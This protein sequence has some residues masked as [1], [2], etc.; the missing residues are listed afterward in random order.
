MSTFSIVGMGCRYPGADNLR[1]YWSM[2]KDKKSGISTN[3]HSSKHT[4]S[5]SGGRID[6]HGFDPLRFGISPKEAATMDPQQ[7]I[8]LH[9]VD[10]AIQD[11]GMNIHGTRTGVFIGAGMYDHGVTTLQR[12]E[13]TNTHTMTSCALSIIANRISYTFGLTGPSMVIDTACS[14]SM[15][16]LHV[17][18]R[19]LEAGDCDCIIVGGV[20]IISI[21]GGTAGFTKLGVVSD[22]GQCMAFDQQADGYIRSEGMGAIVIKRQ[23]VA[24]E[25]RDRIYASINM[26]VLNH[27]GHNES[28]TMPNVDQ[29]TDLLRKVYNFGDGNMTVPVY[30]EAHGTGTSV[31]DPIECRAISSTF[32]GNVISIGS[33]KNNIGHTECAAAMASIIKCALMVYHRG[34]LPTINVS[35]PN[36]AIDWTSLRLVQEYTPYTSHEDMVIGINCFGFGGANGHVRMM[37]PP[38]LSEETADRDDPRWTPWVLGASTTASLGTLHTAWQ[39]YG[40]DPNTT[41]TINSRSKGSRYIMTALTPP[42]TTTPSFG[43]VL[44]PIH[45]KPLVFV[46]NGQG[47]Q[48]P[49]MGRELYAKF[50]IFRY[51]VDRIDAIWQE[52]GGRSLLET[53]GIFRGEE[54]SCTMEQKTELYSVVYGMVAN[55]THQLAL[56]SLLESIGIKPDIVIGHSIGEFAA[57]YIAGSM[58]IHTTV[59]LLHNRMLALQSVQDCGTMLAVNGVHD[60]QELCNG[61]DEVWMAADNAPGCV[62]LGGTYDAIDAIATR[63]VDQGLFHRRLK[64]T[65]AYHTPLLEPSRNLLEQSLTTLV[66]RKPSIPWISTVTGDQVHVGP[67]TDYFGRN[68]VGAVLFRDA[69]EKTPTD[70]VYV[71]CGPHPVLDGYIA[72]IRPD[73]DRI[74][75]GSRKCGDEETFVKS[76]LGFVT[77]GVDTIRWETVVPKVVIDDAPTFPP[78]NI[79]IRPSTCP[80]EHQYIE[81][82]PRHPLLHRL[83]FNSGDH[84]AYETLLSLN[85]IPFVLDHKIQETPVVPGTMM[86][87]MC[88][89]AAR[90]FLVG[91]TS[92]V[93]V[94]ETTNIQLHR[95]LPASEELVSVTTEIHRVS[96]ESAHVRICVGTTC[97]AETTVSVGNMVSKYLDILPPSLNVSTLQTK[98]HD[99]IYSEL[100][101]V[102][103]SYGETFRL[104]RSVGFDGYTGTGTIDATSLGSFDDYIVHPCILDDALHAV[105][106]QDMNFARTPLPVKIDRVRYYLNGPV[107]TQTTCYSQMT[108]YMDGKETVKVW[109]CD[110]STGTVLSVMD[111][112]Q[113]KPLDKIYRTPRYMYRKWSPDTYDDISNYLVL[114][115]DQ[116]LEWQRECREN[117]SEYHSLNVMLAQSV[118]VA[119]EKYPQPPEDA[120]LYVVRQHARCLEEYRKWLSRPQYELK[121]MIPDATSLSFLGEHM[122][123]H[124]TDPKSFLPRMFSEGGMDDIYRDS[125]TFKT[126]CKYIR[127]ILQSLFRHKPDA[128]I[129]EI[130]AGTGGFTK[131]VIDLLPPSCNYTYS[132]TSTY[133][134]QNGTDMGL[135]TRVVDISQP[136]DGE[137][138]DLIIG[139]DVVH[140]TPD[141]KDTLKNLY[142]S[143]VPSGILLIIDLVPV[144]IWCL[145]VLFHT[146]EGWTAVSDGRPHCCIEKPTWRE[147]LTSVGFHGATTLDAYGVDHDDQSHL[148]VIVAGQKGPEVESDKTYNSEPVSTAMECG[149]MLKTLTDEVQQVRIHAHP[150]DEM[151]AH[152]IEGL[153]RSVAHEHP[154][155]DIRTLIG[156]SSGDTPVV[157]SKRSTVGWVKGVSW[158]EELVPEDMQQ[159]SESPQEWVCVVDDQTHRVRTELTT[160]T[161]LDEHEIRVR[162]RL[163]GLNFRDAAFVIGLINA[164]KEEGN[165]L[166]GEFG[167]TV[168]ETGSGVTEIQ[169]GDT[170]YGIVSS[171][172]SFSSS[173]VAHKDLTWVSNGNLEE[174]VAT[175]IS[176]ITAYIGLIH[177][178]HVGQNEHVVV[179]SGTGALGQACI[180]IALNA[181]CVVFAT[182]STETKRKWLL[183]TFPS[184]S[185]VYPSR[186]AEWSQ[187]IHPSSVDVMIGALSGEAMDIGISA[188]RED[189][190]YIDVGKRDIRENRL[191]G[192][193]M[194]AKNISY[195]SVQVDVMTRSVMGRNLIRN[196]VTTMSTVKSIPIQDIFT[197]SNVN[198]AVSQMLQATHTGKFLISIGDVFPDN[199]ERTS[200][201]IRLTP[202]T[203]VYIA[204]GMCEMGL[205]VALRLAQRGATHIVLTSRRG[206]TTGKQYAIIE[207]IERTGCR[208]V[209]MQSNVIKDK[210]YV[211]DGFPVVDIVLHMA[212]VLRDATLQNTNEKDA[213]TVWDTKVT[214]CKRLYSAFGP[215]ASRFV[216]FSSIA[217]IIGNAGQSYYAAASGWFEGFARTHKNVSSIHINAIDDVGT[218]ACNMSLRDAFYA[219]GFTIQTSSV[220]LCDALEFVLQYTPDQ[221]IMVDEYT[222]MLNI[223]TSTGATVISGDTTALS[224]SDIVQSIVCDVLHLPTD[225]YDTSTPWIS[226]GVD[227]LS[228]VTVVNKLNRQFDTELTQVRV[229]SG[230]CSDD[231][232]SMVIQ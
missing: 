125:A 205:V 186:N 153:V 147:A 93:G 51:T 18:L 113:F 136:I 41:H 98:E 16:A 47:A 182:A 48:Y 80:N 6:V 13:A 157:P 100:R 202:H 54:G 210:L 50:P 230:I 40:I 63:C 57:G 152:A 68:L 20:N 112:I 217:S 218:F 58:D 79:I 184:L 220:E 154:N 175:L 158:L 38:C 159:G 3:I 190:R 15:T 74:V 228:A 82:P 92:T 208:V 167:G 61:V 189:G 86:L 139:L 160:I 129:L 149:N 173:V 44:G 134:L 146:F 156:D 105:I 191:L 227:S 226:W 78:E 215:T 85:T 124:W 73:A 29:H 169:P 21:P 207:D 192:M 55:F 142:D 84:A 62:T 31:G 135:S 12:P 165:Y 213:L 211:P 56:C 188:L 123:E 200:P 101:H 204:G 148:H 10:E 177:R 96:E 65:C 206:V 185:G 30:I 172:G 181:G 194:F 70:A 9:I 72:S 91:E 133:F 28:L 183:E 178:A 94:L 170:V 222:N 137:P 23:H 229:L 106:S 141:I 199:L 104:L 155:W 214:G 150:L 131:R 69:I 83:L 151:E 122:V 140:A 1:G 161:P 53:T 25:S 145:D 76:I 90:N 64:V 49:E 99:Q 102:G 121:S 143:L 174:E 103:L 144:D 193:G 17:G 116:L 32:P 59:R 33:V 223:H 195:M 120:P 46:F 60:L 138:Y 203:T 162:P 166:G 24:I 97:H 197:I 221:L 34:L 11:S 108:N 67:D 7:R 225:R 117:M 201:T 87:E 111:G 126:P 75:L 8:A 128:R 22:S 216:L 180:S 127:S 4:A 198:E 42:G 35:T 52:N 14:S 179:H 212:L 196:A 115:Q 232:V 88:T 176:H 95:M 26:T 37:S 110:G 163:V 219:K 164:T 45:K 107:P 187:Y 5:T 2:M 39:S 209:V 89:A 81:T 231:F 119:L 27:D 118:S 71:S 132:D 114:P 171:K 224:I 77:A 109:L 168:I 36:P 130:G 19:A 43:N 66:C